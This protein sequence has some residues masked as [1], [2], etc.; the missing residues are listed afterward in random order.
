MSAAVAHGSRRSYQLLRC[1]CVRCRAANADYVRSRRGDFL[2]DPAELVD[3]KPAAAHLETLKA[4]GVGYRQAGTL[5]G[6]DQGLIKEIRSGQRRQIRADTSTRI[7]GIRGALAPGQRVLSWRTLRF[8]DSLTREGFHKSDLAQKLG[9]RDRYLRLQTR[10]HIRVRNACKVRN[11]W[12][13]IMNED[14]GAIVIGGK[15]EDD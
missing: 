2:P 13:L 12:T 6:L 11:L 8:L 14:G 10:R 7:L 5:A 15:D 3:A 9:L 4:Q 1:R